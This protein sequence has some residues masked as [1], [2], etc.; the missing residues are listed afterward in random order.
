MA[1]RDMEISFIP[2]PAFNLTNTNESDCSS[3]GH[4]TPDVSSLFSKCKAVSY[5]AKASLCSRS[6]EKIEIWL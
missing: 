4:T 5:K 6:C 3:P 2:A 1:Q